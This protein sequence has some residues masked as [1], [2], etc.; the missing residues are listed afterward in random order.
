LSQQQAQKQKEPLQCRSCN[1]II[2]F[3]PNHRRENGS[4]IRLNPDMSVHECKP[5]KDQEQQ[6]QPIPPNGTN[7]NAEVI[8]LL[9]RAIKLL[10]E[11]AK[12]SH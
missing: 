2:K 12:G 3:H 9:R 6:Q 5:K 8:D 11:Q 10:E 4:W 7:N 1:E